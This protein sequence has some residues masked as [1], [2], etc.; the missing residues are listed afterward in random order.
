MT[1]ESPVI[2]FVDDEK[3]VLD[4]LRR[5]LWEQQDDW[6]MAF[7]IGADQALTWM[8]TRQ[9]DVV[10]TD[11]RMPG[12]NGD[13]LLR[14]VQALYPATA[15]LILSGHFDQEAEIRTSGLAHAYLLKPCPTETLIAAIRRVLGG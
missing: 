13:E 10:V 14:R 8:Q 9:P 5:C 12:M 3:S 4:G 11:M 7:A 1:H 6:Q 2:L 15:R